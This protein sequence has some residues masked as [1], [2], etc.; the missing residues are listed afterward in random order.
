MD[1]VAERLDAINLTLGRQ[2]EVMAA[3]LLAMPK[4]AGRFISGLEVAV[5]VAGVLAIFST[6]DVVWG[7][8]TG[9]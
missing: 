8:I 5:L 4:P 3:M 2:N 9:G 7:W 1:K 6:A